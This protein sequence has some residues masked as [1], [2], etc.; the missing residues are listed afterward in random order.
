M[1]YPDLHFL[2]ANDLAGLN[3][4]YYDLRRT[5]R[6]GILSDVFEL[7]G[8]LWA[9]RSRPGDIRIVSREFPWIIDIKANPAPEN[10]GG[11][12][13]G[14]IWISLYQELLKPLTDADW[15]LLTA[16]ADLGDEK[17][18]QRLTHLTNITRR[19]VERGEQISLRRLDWLMR[20]TLFI[21]LTKDD[22]SRLCQRYILPG[23]ALVS[24][25]WVAEFQERP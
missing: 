14:D 12:T 2:L 22:E 1:R 17:T 24:E 7:Y 20:K 16:L 25:T 13:C 19:Q 6:D 4:F 3:R 9:M 18:I 15:A 5:P 21:G 23:S 10:E 11:V 8:S